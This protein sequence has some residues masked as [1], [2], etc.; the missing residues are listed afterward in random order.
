MKAAGYAGAHGQWH[1]PEREVKLVFRGARAFADQVD[2]MGR[3]KGRKVRQDIHV[4]YYDHRQVLDGDL[5][6]HQ[7]G[8][9]FGAST[10]GPSSN[11]RADVRAPTQSQIG[12]AMRS[13]D[14]PGNFLPGPGGK[15]PAAVP[16]PRLR[17]GI[18]RSKGNR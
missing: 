9:C 14:E 13:E 3:L 11:V 17:T 12:Q 16:L 2:V 15:G 7:G 6:L 1:V 10:Q 8:P 4:H 5:H 18:G